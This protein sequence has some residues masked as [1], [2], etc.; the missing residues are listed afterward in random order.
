M[1]GA[2]ADGQG[3]PYPLVCTVSDDVIGNLTRSLESYLAHEGSRRRLVLATSVALTTRRRRNL[4]QRAEEMGFSLTQ[5]YDQEAIADRLYNCERW[6]RELL[7]I[8]WRPQALSPVPPPGRTYLEIDLIGRDK[9]IEWLENTTDDRLIAGQP[10]SGKTFLLHH[11]TRKGWGVFLHS[12]DP[13]AIRNALCEQRP[14]VVILDDAHEDAGRLLTLRDLRQQIDQDFDIVATCWKGERD[15]VA[16]ALGSLPASQIRLL[17]LLTRDQIVDVFRQAGVRPRNESLRELVDQAAN[18]PG[19]A[20]TL[21]TLWLRGSRLDVLKGEALTRS[22]MADFKN[23]VDSDSSDFLAVL[24]VGGERGMPL[25]VAGEYLGFG[26]RK[27]RQLAIDLV[28]GG[29][30]FEREAHVLEVRPVALRSTL[31]RQTFFEGPA[32]LDYRPLLEKAPSFESAVAAII[33]AALGAE[34]PPQELRDLVRSTALPEPWQR[35]SE[36]C[37][38]WQL[39]TG[40][41]EDEASWVLDNYPG[42]VV[43]IASRAL[44]HAPRATIPRLLERAASDVAT[45]EP[46]L[47]FRDQPLD[48]LR[49][50]M[51]DVSAEEARPGTLVN[52]RRLAV[53]AAKRSVEGGGSRDVAVQVLFMAIS[54]RLAGTSRDPGMG[55]TITMR[56]GLL[57]PDQLRELETLWEEGRGVISEID[58]RVWDG[59]QSISWDWSHPE[60]VTPGRPLDPAAR[61]ALSATARRVLEDLAPLAEGSPGLSAGLNHLARRAGIELDLPSDPVFELLYP[62]NHPRGA[63]PDP[64]TMDAVDDLAGRWSAERQ[65]EEAAEALVRYEDEA[66]RIGQHWPRLTPELC[67]LLAERVSDPERWAETFLDHRL[68]ADLL[69]PLLEK[70]VA[71]RRPRWDRILARCLQ[72]DEQSWGAGRMVLQLSEPPVDLLKLAL[73]KASDFPQLIETLCLRREVP[74]ATLEALLDH[75]DPRVALAAA[76]GEWNADPEGRVTDPIRAQWREVIL[77][78]AQLGSEDLAGPVD[79]GYWLGH[80][81]GSDSTLARDWLEVLIDRDVDLTFLT[82]GPVFEALNALTEADRLQILG[83]LQPGKFADWELPRLVNRNAAVYRRLLEIDRLKGCQLRPLGGEP[84]GNWPELAKLALEAGHDPL[85]IARAAFDPTHVFSEYSPSAWDR[86]FAKLEDDLDPN[87]REVARH[88]RKLAQRDIQRSAAEQR[89]L[90]LEGY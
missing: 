80:I 54:P 25:E 84:D 30:L 39:Y 51:L 86:S 62:P 88:G 11:L 9:D 34:D 40:L 66:G 1:D 79:L 46:V 15:S 58:S 16:E 63:E 13:A 72:I 45:D 22:L 82:R 29:V 73:T 81:L 14:R 53:Q 75:P 2:V 10:G 19:L 50:W 18:K 38:V 26:L 52:R 37:R 6:C 44:W 71:A 68:S 67:R 90:E 76:V 35:R 7:S 3:E 24:G 33:T 69:R 83:K 78:S 8:T 12:D 70:M 32:K 36:A 47:T 60:S 42:D 59:L 65:P 64:A 85:A 61:D 55:R 21:A 23:L 27:A 4:H 77:R 74:L 28:T 57:P 87:L 48:L 20:V 49:N 17:E 41:G 56:Q 5:V 31:I 43:D 89:E